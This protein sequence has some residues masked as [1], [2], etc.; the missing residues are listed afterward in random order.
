VKG[1]LSIK[2]PVSLSLFVFV[3]DG[4][5][6]VP[7]TSPICRPPPSPPAGRLKSGADFALKLVGFLHERVSSRPT[8]FHGGL[9]IG[10]DCHTIADHSMIVCA[11][12]FGKVP[13]AHLAAYKE[14]WSPWNKVRETRNRPAIVPS[15]DVLA[16]RSNTSAMVTVLKGSFGGFSIPPKL[17]ILMFQAPEVL[18]MW[19]SIGLYGEQGLQAG[20]G[21]YGQNALKF[22]GAT[23]LERGAGFRSAM[24]LTSEAGVDVLAR[25]VA[26]RKPTAAGARKA[27]KVTD[28]REPENKPPL[29]Q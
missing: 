9:F 21:G 5:P 17:H 4:S 28:E 20:R 10:H 2:N 11:A 18:G 16:F 25:Y 8:S 26:R 27:T 7:P 14:A 19:G 1:I 24:A 22:P 29:L 6:H 3:P 15:E 13:L 23:E 12:L